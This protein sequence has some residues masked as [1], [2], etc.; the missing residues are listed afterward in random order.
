MRHIKTRKTMG[1]KWVKN[2]ASASPRTLSLTSCNLELWPP[3]PPK[4][5]ISRHCPMD[6]L[7]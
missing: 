7:C 2:D 6:H 1:S 3:E 4:V 5:D